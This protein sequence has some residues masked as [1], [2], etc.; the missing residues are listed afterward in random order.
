MPM[1]KRSFLLWYYV[2]GITGARHIF[3]NF[4]RFFWRYFS[5]I[6][7][8]R[9]LLSPWHH[10][11]TV[12]SWRGFRPLLALTRAVSNGIS[13][14]LGLWARLVVIFAG[15]SLS[16][17]ALLLAMFLLV[18][19]I[20][21]PAVL[22]ISFALLLTSPIAGGISFAL[23][24]VMLNLYYRGYKRSARKPY[25]HMDMIELSKQKWFERVW[26]RLGIA[27][28]SIGDSAL[29]NFKTFSS[30]LLQSGIAQED[31]AHVLKW[32]QD[33]EEQRDHE[34]AFWRW[35]NLKK[36]RPLGQWWHY[37]YTTH[38]DQFSLD[39]TKNDPTEYND[40]ILVDHQSEMELLEL[41][42]SRPDQNNALFI[43]PAGIGKQTIAHALARRIRT[44]FYDGTI[45][46]D[47]RVLLFDASR[48]ITV[49]RDRGI[50]TEAML[51]SLCMEATIAGNV[52]LIIDDLEQYFN[53]Q[54]VT[55]DKMIFSS[56]LGRFLSYPTFRIVA[57]AG[58]K[59]FHKYISA[60]GD[61]L[62]QFEII[63]VKELTREETGRL[64]YYHAVHLEKQANRVIVDYGAIRSI[65]DH[66]AAHRGT[67]PLPERAHDLFTE[68]LLFWQNNQSSVFVT[69]QTVDS[70]LSLKTGVPHGIMTETEKIQLLTLEET[71]H[72]RIVGQEEAVRQISESIRRMRAGVGDQMKP[73]GSFLF[74]GPTGVGKTETAK[75]LAASYFGD[76]SRMM[77]LDMSEY[78]QPESVAQLIGSEEGIVGRLSS[79]AKD[80]PFALLLLDE[81]EKAH[82]DVQDLF[83]QILDEGIVTDGRGEKISLRD[84][85]IIATSNAGSH[86]LATLLK[87]KTDP[88]SLTD[89]LIE[90]LVKDNIFRVE[91]LNRFSDIIVF[92]PLSGEQLRHVTNLLLKRFATRVKEE[93]NLTLLY[94]DSVADAVIAK[95]YKNIFGAR[96]IA[97][98]IEDSVED[99]LA[100]K[101]IEGDVMRGENITIGARD[102]G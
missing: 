100:T 2:H 76:E 32:E 42:L 87:E 91:F 3:W 40:E 30:F 99:A 33:V 71:L 26:K 65:V 102:L 46:S 17:G 59:Q 41:I 92:H 4:V 18:W 82:R 48:A 34:R 12:R 43:G 28:E 78:N 54:D 70:Y 72:E 94:D 83:L 81:I 25:A 98:Y 97:R 51:E 61:L 96:S 84:M 101:L 47:Q 60:R 11:V 13:R 80:Q 14:F 21:M 56:V 7:L 20:V 23:S 19:S 95:G 69:K 74:L 10:D 62:K 36:I 39:L 52:I 89:A 73:I 57:L 6:L 64:L 63:T 79:A 53:E 38:L 93:K 31:F 5:V 44:G 15:V 86:A 8:L 22:F 49:A 75:A 37:G 58:E 1:Q 85:V 9:T 55:S 45:L 68:V 50:D 24:L 27:P 66:A 77:R 90:T 67:M 88:H 35:N 16:M 29:D